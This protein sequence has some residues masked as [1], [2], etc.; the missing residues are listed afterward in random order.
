MKTVESLGNDE[1]ARR[2]L[3]AA[4]RERLARHEQPTT[5]DDPGRLGFVHNMNPR[6]AKILSA[7]NMDKEFVKGDGLTLED[8]TGNR[9]LDFA[10]AYGALPFGHRPAAIWSAINAVGTSGEAVFVQPA[11]LSAAGELASR[12]GQVAP[13]GL[14]HVTYV[15]SGAE[16]TEIAIKIAR[17]STGRLGVLSTSNSFHGKTLGALSA[18]GRDK[19]QAG[20]GAPAAGFDRIPFGDTEALLTALSAEPG[21]YAMFLVEP[22]QGEGGVVVPPDGYLKAARQACDRHGVLLVVDEVQ[23]GLGRTG[24]MFA[25]EHEAVSPDIITLAKA[26]GGGVV[27][28]GAVLTRPELVT[29]S[30]SLRHTSTFAGNALGARVGIAVLDELA[31]N[32]RRLVRSAESKGALLKSELSELGRRYPSVVRDVRGR[33]LLLGVELSSDV[34]FAGFQNLLGSIADQENL[35]MVV[36][37]YLLNVEGIRLAPTLFGSTV[38]RVEP[39]LTVTESECRSFVAAMDRALAALAAGDTETILGHLVGRTQHRSVTE[40]R[41]RATRLPYIEPR[42]TDARFAFVAHPLDLRSFA[43]F[44]PALGAFDAAQRRDLLDRMAGASSTLNPAPFLVGSGRVHSATGCTAFGELVGLPYTAADLLDLPPTRSVELV[45]EAVDWAADRGA[46]LVG[47]GAYSSIVTSNAADLR[48][49]RLP[50]TTGNAFTAAASVTAVRSLCES[51]GLALAD[52]RVVIIGAGGAIGRTIAQQLA[53][54]TGTLVLVG[55]RGS[56]QSTSG[57]LWSAAEELARTVDAGSVQQLIADERIVLS[58][59]PVAAV[60]GAHVIFAATSAPQPLLDASEL[61][62]GAIVCDVAQPPNIPAD[63]VRLRPDVT[64][65]DGGIVSLPGR[66]DFDLRYGLPKG[67][68]YA[69]MAETMLIALSGESELVSRGVRLNHDHV[70]RLGELARHHGFSLA[71]ATTWRTQDDSGVQ[72]VV[73][74]A[75]VGSAR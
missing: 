23:T 35:A 34:N 61:P 53:D 24:R 44:D 64:V 49:T 51:R 26:L 60:K 75:Q 22:I 50:V 17:S 32:D 47:L 29:E 54:E 28:T 37:S 57:S 40:V 6:L 31:A 55:R 18:T 36:C 14:T 74:D 66:S 58:D 48:T 52:T 42:S 39:P 13:G 20:F 10:G 25:C 33:G 27:P 5:S 59:D 11:V 65:F 12:L 15:N 71:Q 9:Y 7:L 69:C 30:F 16:A 45:A 19:Y 4:V 68:T 38:L 8:R 56:V 21:K 73:T 3:L 1:Q 63:V 67:L 72:A 46:T 43:D 41:E 2:K 62:E 70:G